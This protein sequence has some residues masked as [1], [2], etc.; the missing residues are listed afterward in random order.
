MFG[1]IVVNEKE[2]KIKDYETYRAYYCGLC[3]SLRRSYGKIGQLTLSYDMT[4]LSILLNSLYESKID[5]REKICIVH[6]MK[7]HKML[8]NEISEYAADMGLLLSY[9]NLMDDWK[10]DKSIK[11]I[12]LGKA[13]EGK[14]KE[15]EK[16]YKRQGKAVKEYILELSKLEAEDEKDIDKISGLT[17][18]LLAEI[19]N[20]KDDFWKDDIKAMGFYLGKFIYL[21]DAY[22][23]IEED[24]K[25][26]RYNPW[27]SYK[28]E[29]DFHKNVETILTMM[30]AQAA[31][32]FERLPLIQDVEILRN[33]IYSGVWSKFELIKNKNRETGVENDNRSI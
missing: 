5:E 31:A 16:N 10:D 12:F 11:G 9:Y 14:V 33:I 15:I 17:G 29:E 22:E 7:K 30:M 28:E 26:G 2:L 32:A 27:K 1:Y 19:F 3:E 24:I 20:Y 21:M 4:F 18:S 13:I 6:P 25:K 8:T 23:D